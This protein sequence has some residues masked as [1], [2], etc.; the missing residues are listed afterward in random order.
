MADAYSTIADLPGERPL[1][2]LAVAVLACELLGSLGNLASAGGVTE[3]YPTLTKPAYTPPNWVFGPVWVT[4]FALMGVAVWLVWRQGL[5]T[6]PVRIAL[7]LFAVHFVFNVAWSGAF[8]GLRSPAAGLAV[9]AV[10]LIAIGA[11]MTAFARVDRR[12][13]LLL[14]PYLVWTG[15]AAVLNYQ[16]WRLN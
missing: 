3:W 10:L 2:S 1:A 4:L 7:A 5:D 11:T 9:I 14:V 12:A 15:F 6:R 16:L 8:F 13:A